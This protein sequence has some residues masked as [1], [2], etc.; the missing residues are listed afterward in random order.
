MRPLSN[1]LAI[2]HAIIVTL[3]MLLLVAI[4]CMTKSN[5]LTTKSQSKT[6]HSVLVS[7]HGLC[8]KQPRALFSVDSSKAND[9]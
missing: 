8:G 4:Y 3:Q 9:R 2:V 6:F 5:P 1:S 7:S